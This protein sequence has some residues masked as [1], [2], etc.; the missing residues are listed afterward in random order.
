[1]NLEGLFTLSHGLYL[2][3]SYKDRRTNGQISNAV[4]QVTDYALAYLDLRVADSLD[5][6]TH[7]FFVGQLVDSRLIGQGRPMTYAYYR[8]VLRG[9]SPPTAP[10][11][12]AVPMQGLDQTAPGQARHIPGSE[13][14][15]TTCE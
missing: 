2:L 1:M 8:N 11:Y 4:V 10:T 6:G 12:R 3:S 5:V 9:K 15:A 13:M 7:T 14:T